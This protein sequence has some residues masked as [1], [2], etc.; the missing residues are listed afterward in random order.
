MQRALIVP[1]TL[2][3]EIVDER[4]EGGGGIGRRWRR[5]TFDRR[6]KEKNLLDDPM[7]HGAQLT[8]S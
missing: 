5:L 7:Q 2:G 8:T 1:A 4:L 6:S 3:G